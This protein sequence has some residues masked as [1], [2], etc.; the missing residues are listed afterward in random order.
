MELHIFKETPARIPRQKL[1]R[2]FQSIVAH[3]FDPMFPS[4]INVVFVDDERIKVLNREFRGL[5]RPT[6]VLSFVVDDIHEDGGT[7]GEIYISCNRALQQAGTYNVSFTEEL[8]R[9][10]A[11]GMLHLAGWDHE[12]DE[13][14]R[15]MQQRE[16][17]FLTQVED[18]GGEHGK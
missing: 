3:E 11:H 6:D 10:F 5:D 18:H 8:L 4:Q 2:L 7:F 9:L 12:D 15:R 1:R 13:S 17:F 16:D 14:L